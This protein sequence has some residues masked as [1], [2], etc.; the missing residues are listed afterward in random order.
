MTLGGKAYSFAS[1]T[2]PTTGAG[3]NANSFSMDLFATV[4]G[5]GGGTILRMGM[6]AK[7]GG[8]W[9]G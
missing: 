5:Y 6:V 2:Q 1:C 7:T 8:G 9:A 3:T 4:T